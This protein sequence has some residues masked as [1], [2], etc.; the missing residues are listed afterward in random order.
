MSNTIIF[1]A[2]GSDEESLIAY[3]ESLGLQFVPGG[4]DYGSEGRLGHGFISP[5]PESELRTGGPPGFPLNY[6]DVWD[7]LI[8]FSFCKILPSHLRPGRITRNLDNPDLVEKTKLNYGRIY[9]WIK[10]NWPKNEISSD[11]WCGPEARQLIE[12]RGLVVTDLVPG[13]TITYVPID[14]AGSTFE[15]KY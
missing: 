13:T 5:F 3:I 12:S 8:S 10:K 6:Y 14:P 2:V 15:V 4:P 1:A 7:P 9:R 11:C